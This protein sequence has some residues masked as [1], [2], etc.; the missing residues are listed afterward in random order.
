L[1]IRDVSHSYAARRAL[2]DVDFAVAP[3]SFTALL[4]LNG[5]GKSTLFAFATAPSAWN[6]VIASRTTT[7]M[8]A[9]KA[10]P[11][12]YVRDQTRTPPAAK[13]GPFWEVIYGS[14]LHRRSSGARDIFRGA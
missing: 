3:A 7:A 11:L 1:S 14:A 10:L 2:A 4:G 13:N 9:P 12:I 5:A 8:S 6:G